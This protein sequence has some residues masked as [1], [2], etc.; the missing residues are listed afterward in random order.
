VGHI[1][2]GGPGAGVQLWWQV[3]R[4]RVLVG[5]SVVLEVLQPPVSGRLHRWGLQ[6][7]LVDTSERRFDSAVTAVESS[8][9]LA[10]RA[11]PPAV[12]LVDPAMWMELEAPPDDPTVVAR[13]SSPT[14]SFDDGSLA[15]VE[16]VLV[17]FPTG[18]EWR[19]VDVV[20]DEVGVLM[21]TNT[22]RRT[23]NLAVLEFPT[24][25]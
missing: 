13:W 7:G 18:R 19:R 20:T 14:C 6:A 8:S 25:R 2:P 22:R 9:S 23:A 4:G 15:P 11:R 3:P 12:S 17:T 1:E 21:V 5:V 16:A 24:A 10:L